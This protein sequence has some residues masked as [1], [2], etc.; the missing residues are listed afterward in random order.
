MLSVLL[1]RWVSGEKKEPLIG[2]NLCSRNNRE[3][4]ITLAGWFL[5]TKLWL[6]ICSSST[7]DNSFVHA[8]FHSHRQSR[9]TSEA[10]VLTMVLNGVESLL[11]TCHAL[12]VWFR[13]TLIFCFPSSSLSRHI[14][15]FSVS[16]RFFGVPRA[17]NQFLPDHSLTTREDRL[18]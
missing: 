12:S 10:F 7:S 4:V 18:M 9:L 1:S 14:R 16:W 15:P 11:T 8:T 3:H 17:Q 5:S 6:T 13:F 2:Q